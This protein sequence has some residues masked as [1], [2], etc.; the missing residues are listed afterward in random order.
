MVL[1]AARSRRSSPELV[2]R[3][4]ELA[5]LEDDL[6]RVAAGEFRVVL[7]FGE[8]GVGKSRLAREL[9]ARH[10]E[11]TGLVAQAY[12]LAAS[13]AFGLWT[14][15]V[16]PF[17][18]SLP[19]GDVVELCGG[20]LDDLANL[21]HRVALVRGSVPDGDPPLPRL[22]E[23]LA[24]LL[25]SVSRHRP[26]VVLL[27]DVH[28]ADASSWEAL[29]YFARHLDDARLLVVA[30]SRP[31]E[32]VD[33][34]VA[35][36]VL[37]ELDQDS[38]LSRL[39]VGPLARPGLGELA[40]AVIGRPAPRALV[41]WLAERS[42]GNPLFAIGLLRA[43]SEE[44][45]DLAA[46]VLR[47]LPEGLTEGVTSELR[48]AL[49]PAGPRCHLSGDERRHPAGAAPAGGAFA[50]PRW[51]SGRG[52]VALRPL[53]RARRFGGGRGAAGRD[54]AGGTA[55]GVPG[56]HPLVP[57]AHGEILI[58]GLIRGRP[59]IPQC[60]SRVGRAVRPRA[61]RC[62]PAAGSGRPRAGRA[63]AGSHG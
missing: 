4:Q 13:A 25:G 42:Q 48:R 50:A 14:E 18:R 11:V 36:Q 61:S 53:G 8:A 59:V 55:G 17:L 62:R 22:L 10:G 63:R 46:R 51:V 44:R 29:R 15:A 39:E 34:A 49:S 6:S 7:L 3:R 38:L 37:F 19:D 26:L 9:L 27:D 28:G 23:G 30:T 43:L 41:D 16:D 1:A 12:P 56:A 33:H 47:R 2:G 40:E 58:A 45:A 57:A 24:G 32:L 54:A 52:G 60:G 20:L 35:V 21:F 5:A 31:A